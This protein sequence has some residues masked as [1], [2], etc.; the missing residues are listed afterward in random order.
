LTRPPPRILML[1]ID[2]LPP[3]LVDRWCSDGTLP[4]MAA[5][6]GRA[7]CGRVS[8]G[9]AVFPGSVW[10][11]FVTGSDVAH[12]GVYHA[13][14]W[15]PAAMRIRTPTREGWLEVRPFWHDLA[16]AG[17]D[18][19]AFDVPFSWSAGAPLG[20]VEVI[21]WGAHE[22]LWEA[23]RPA[24]L[25]RELNRRFGPSS[26][27]RDVQ[28]TKP[29]G[30]LAAELQGIVRDVGRR[31]RILEHLLKRFDW[32][33]AIATFA[34]VHRAGHWFWSERTTGEAQGGLRT[35]MRAVDAEIAALEALLGPE[36][37]LVL[38]SVHGMGPAGDADR[39]ADVLWRHLEPALDRSARRQLDPVRA[40]RSLLPARLLRGLSAR[41]PKSAYIRF[42]EHYL[43][44][45]RDWAA[46]RTISLP[47]ELNYYLRANLA[48]REAPG[49]VPANELASYI[50]WLQEELG[51][52]S[53]PDGSGVFERVVSIEDEYRGRNR[54]LLPDVV[55]L[56]QHRL[57]G[58]TI[59]TGSGRLLTAPR[60]Y[61]VDGHH[62]ADG[63]YIHAGPSIPKGA[64]PAVDGKHLAAFLLK[65]SGM[66]LPDGLAMPPNLSIP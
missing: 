36:D 25:L 33:L 4:N 54:H 6:R 28:G 21:G 60:R 35:V 8:S 39:F 11:T 23:S 29:P 65:S 31:A 9:A 1:G 19:L 41:L 34:E 3:E 57:L 32:R 48:G 46:Y 62:T 45:G 15:D 38:F 7:R 26:L 55:A 40:L 17:L 61:E 51:M 47:P 43:N 2:A 24:G 52:I 53:T 10:P 30:W 20:V 42:H 13:V 63:F 16:S 58:G 44:A 18:V 37:H 12:H 50:A 49:K 56:P 64:G 66:P 27:Y 5:I 59:R 14:Q 22:G